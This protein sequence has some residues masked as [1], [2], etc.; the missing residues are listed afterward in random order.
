M[1]NR[2]VRH[3]NH[4]KTQEIHM[5][6]K[7][8]KQNNMKQKKNVR[9]VRRGNHCQTQGIHIFTKNMLTKPQEKQS[10]N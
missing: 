2:L 10:I 9:W 6:I 5:F 7:S 3:W 4:Y 8:N 1:N